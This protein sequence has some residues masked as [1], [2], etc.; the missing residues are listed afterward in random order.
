MKFDIMGRIDNMNLPDGKTAIVYSVYEAVSNAIHAIQDRFGP[1]NGA[2]NGLVNIDIETDDEGEVSAITVEDNGIGFT[3]DNIDSFE[4]SDS[5]YKYI[6]GGKGV[7]R[8]IWIKMFERIKVSSTTES[9][10]S[11]ERITFT[12]DP[13]QAKSVRYL[14]R[15]KTSSKEFGS[16]I[17]IFEPRE[18]GVGHINQATFMKDLALHFFPQFVK[19]TLPAITLT[20]DGEQRNLQDYISSRVGESQSEKIN[21]QVDGR[22]WT[23]DIEHLY[24]DPKLGAALKNSY[25]LTAHGRLVGDPTPLER[26]FAL[27]DLPHGKAYVAVVSSPE[28]DRR[29]DQ[30]R[31]G[32]KL[33]NPQSEA[34]RD[35][36]LAAAE[37]F[38]GE[39]IAVVRAK[40]KKTVE[41]LLTEH[42]QLASQIP[43]LDEYI[44]S[45]YPGMDD[46]QIGQNLFVL[47]Y[48][49]ERDNR[50]S[51]AELSR[52]D[53]LDEHDQEEARKTL[54]SLSNQEK[55]RLAELV[56]K[57]HQVLQTA[58]MLL[59]YADETKETYHYEKVVHDL[60]CPM[61]KMY[62]SGDYE[63]HNLW[64]LDDSLA[65]YQMFS[66]DR[67]INQITDGDSKKE[68]DLVFFNPLG[69][70][71][72]GA[73]TTIVEFKR[74]G[75]GSPSSDPIKQVLGYIDDLRGHNAKDV[76]GTLITEIDD[77]TPFECIVVCELNEQTRKL[78]KSSLAQHPMPD[79][80]GYFGWSTEH[81]A[82]LKVISF[83]KML[84][85][86]TLRNQVFFDA[87]ALGTPSEGARKRAARRRERKERGQ[88]RE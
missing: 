8:F 13:V 67:P 36:V 44:A 74:P 62:K 22:E 86:A 61:G 72:A 2:K 37:R 80:Q 52:L 87:L 20:Y 75:D 78:L 50:K 38:L 59:K 51:L 4:T 16:K 29:V 35:A 54:K 84:R 9:G 12:F 70:R 49:E 81:N 3:K 60:I 83:Q 39:H 18:T 33:T 25:M 21:V 56:V 34:L 71:Q 1:K 58:E 57:R 85:D 46:E 7:G 76:D 5:R 11:A 27:K 43:D 77:K 24:V 69:F 32:F 14:R 40:Q 17:E 30:E 10:K 28:L 55:H 41:A 53:T 42:P 88:T 64:I 65:G 82:Y 68:P 79:G 23:L 26:R 73:T 19:G 15:T 66:S 6:R 47:L 48:R 45:L 63:D 31:L